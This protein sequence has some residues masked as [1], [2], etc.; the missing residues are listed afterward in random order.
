LSLQ[1]FFVPTKK[2]DNSTFL[3]PSGHTP[4][5]LAL[6]LPAGVLADE[7]AVQRT[8]QAP[9]RRRFSNRTSN[10]SSVAQANRSQNVL[11]EVPGVA[12]LIW[13]YFEPEI[14]DALSEAQESLTETNDKRAKQLSNR[15]QVGK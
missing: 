15:K 9:S 13:K 2:F 11:D 4:D 6:E 12:D 1:G 5:R 3:E 7:A 8:R 14:R 10:D